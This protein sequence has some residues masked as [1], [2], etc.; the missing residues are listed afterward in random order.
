MI[1]DKENS[2]KQSKLAELRNARL[3]RLQKPI[4]PEKAAEPKEE[5]VEHKKENPPSPAA[6]TET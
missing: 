6:E 1:S 5:I 3:Q 4:I 2:E